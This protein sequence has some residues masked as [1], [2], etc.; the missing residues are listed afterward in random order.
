MMSLLFNGVPQ[1]L[2]THAGYGCRFLWR[3]KMFLQNWNWMIWIPR[4]FTCL[5]GMRISSHVE[6]AGYSQSPAT[7]VQLTSDEW[8]YYP[9]R[10]ARDAAQPFCVRW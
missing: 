6:Q 10:V 8:R 3:S 7:L 9:K 1:K 4:L 5:R 2:T